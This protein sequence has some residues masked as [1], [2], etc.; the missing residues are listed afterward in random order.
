[1]NSCFL[2][3]APDKDAALKDLD[4]SLTE[5]GTDYVD[6]WYLHAKNSPADVHDDLIE[7]QQIAKKAGKIRFVGVSTH[8]GQKELL[9]WIAQK[10][11]FVLPHKFPQKTPNSNPPC[12]PAHL[13]TAYA[14]YVASHFIKQNP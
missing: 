7:A 4:T 6:I 3:P 14:I 5:L 12:S 13:P 10:G 2:S 1:M 11:V 9:P 8:T